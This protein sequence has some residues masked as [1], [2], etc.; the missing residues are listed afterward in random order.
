MT[1]EQHLAIFKSRKLSSQIREL[2]L[3]KVRRLKKDFL[4]LVG[5]FDNM[6]IKDMSKVAEE[7]LKKWKEKLEKL[8]KEFKAVMVRKGEAAA[9]GDL[10]ENA[11][12]S[13]AVEEAQMFQV[14]I[15]EVKKIISKLESEIGSSGK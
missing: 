13:L 7:K 15:S 10:S 5:V 2:I 1:F 14:R 3:F 8:E 6:N 9:M 12:Y 4:I 11:A